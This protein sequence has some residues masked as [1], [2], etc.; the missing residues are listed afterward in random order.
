MTDVM[1]RKRRAGFSAPPQGLMLMEI[2]YD[3]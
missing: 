2:K 3:I 1:Q